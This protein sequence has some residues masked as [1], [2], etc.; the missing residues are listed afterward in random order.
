MHIAIEWTSASFHA[1]QLGADNTVVAEHR[2]KLLST[3]HG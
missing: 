1:W 2:T 3:M